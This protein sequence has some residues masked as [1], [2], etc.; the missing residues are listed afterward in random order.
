MPVIEASHCLTALLMG[1]HY[2]RARFTIANFFNEIL[3][4]I[5]DL[6]GFQL[7]SMGPNQIVFRV[8]TIKVT[9]DQNAFIIN[10]PVALSKELIACLPQEPADGDVKQIAI[11]GRF[12]DSK[13]DV[14]PEIELQK[15]GSKEFRR[16]FIEES[17]ELVKLVDKIIQGGIPPLRF[18]GLVEYYGIPL[19]TVKWEILDRFTEQAEI[20]DALNTEKMSINRYYF[21]RN[22]E[23]EERC[24]IFK[25]V[26]PN[27]YKRPEAAMAGASFDFQRIPENPKGVAEFGGSREM[28]TSLGIGME[29]MIQ[30]SKFLHFSLRS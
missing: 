11:P 6:S 26:K 28:I 14:P 7:H 18:A 21:P 12:Y 2:A 17:V 23:E 1:L 20:P 16:N 4:S 30:Q 13:F 3:D 10:S 22:Q 5:V 8:G 15:E 9:L 27:D 24:F 25:L 29:R 19:N